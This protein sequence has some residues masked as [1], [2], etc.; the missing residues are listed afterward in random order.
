MEG[1]KRRERGSGDVRK[2]RAAVAEERWS[3]ERRTE[4]FGRETEAG[5]MGAVSAGSET[6]TVR[7]RD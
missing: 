3:Q 7:K 2:G 4:P 6:Y 1:G 5:V